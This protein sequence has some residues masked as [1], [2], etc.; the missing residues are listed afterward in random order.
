VIV[1][2]Q[3]LERPLFVDGDAGRLEQ[4]VVNLLLNAATAMGRA[5]SSKGRITI[6]A[7]RGLPGDD[8]TSEIEVS[9]A[10]QGPGIPPE[11]LDR[12][13]DPFF[14]TTQG[15]GLG[16]SV[17]YGIVR[18]H[19]GTLAARNLEGGGAE[20]TIRLPELASAARRKRA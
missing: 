12:I 7:R 10:D 15:T 11:D 20:F 19:G 18:A 8:G 16:L 1:E 4:V 9:V 2:V 14:T 6:Q 3:G 17:S 5:S 13:F